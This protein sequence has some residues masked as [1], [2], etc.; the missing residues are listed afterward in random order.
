MPWRRKRKPT[1][2]FLPE[3]SCGQGHRESDTDSFWATK[4][5]TEVNPFLNSPGLP[6]PTQLS[7]L[8]PLSSHSPQCSP[9]FHSSTMSNLFKL[10]TSVWSPLTHFHMAVSSSHLGL[11]ANATSSEKP[12]RTILSTRN[13]PATIFYFSLFLIAFTTIWNSSFLYLIPS[14]LGSS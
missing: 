10:R 12:I 4:Q 6:S 11:S 8:W 7:S 14:F 13:N 2:V 9:S 3:K 5:R 1:P